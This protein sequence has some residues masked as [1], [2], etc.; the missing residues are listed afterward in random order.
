MTIGNPSSNDNAKNLLYS[1]PRQLTDD[2]CTKLELQD[3][4]GLLSS[5][6]NAKL[7]KEAA[8]NW[9]KF[10]KRNETRLENK[11]HHAGFFKDRHW[12]IREFSELLGLPENDS[13]ITPAKKRLLLE[14]GC[15][16]GNFFY[17]LLES[18][19]NLKVYACDFSARAIDLIKQHEQYDSENIVAFVADL[20]QESCL[21]PHIPERSIDLVTCV[22]VLSAISPSHH[23]FVA[24]NV[25]SV[26]HHGS[27][28]LFRDYAVNDMAMIRF[29]PGSK[30]SHRFYVRQD[31][32]RAY[33][34]TLEEVVK[35]FADYGFRCTEG[36]Y[37]HRRTTN[38]KEG[39]DAP[40]V[41]LQAK[42]VYERP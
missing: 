8:A 3:K 25:A 12:T 23:G 34:F 22:F 27:V 28:L 6:I 17:P 18:G 30:I 29:K 40:R 7:E 39:I 33:Y 1:K 41:F 32:T 37:L 31:G 36:G 9:D 14:T 24:A 10:Y 26:C 35:L 42:F 11:K 20:T 2:D 19:L 5:F 16:V 4:R 15:G 13:S 38:I 21:S